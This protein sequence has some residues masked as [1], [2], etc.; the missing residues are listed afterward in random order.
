[1]SCVLSM[2]SCAWSGSRRLCVNF[3]CTKGV[4]EF[5]TSIMASSAKSNAALTDATIWSFPTYALKFSFIHSRIESTFEDRSTVLDSSLDVRNANFS[6]DSLISC[7]TVAINYKQYVKASVRLIFTY[8]DGHGHGFK[9]IYLKKI[10]H[11]RV[12]DGQRRQSFFVCLFVTE[13]IQCHGGLWSRELGQSPM[14]LV[15][16]TPRQQMVWQYRLQDRDSRSN[17]YTI[18]HPKMKPSDPLL[19]ADGTLLCGSISQTVLFWGFATFSL[20]CSKYYCSKLIDGLNRRPLEYKGNTLA[21]DN[22]SSDIPFQ[23]ISEG[24]SSIY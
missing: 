10:V 6:T 18:I 2:R 14:L 8:L 4:M 16:L 11:K 3:P 20:S 13:E 19:L 12:I 15:F 17:C 7:A 5:K 24:G 22:V 23:L 21:A 1:M 9:L